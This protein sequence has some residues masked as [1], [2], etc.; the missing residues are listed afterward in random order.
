VYLTAHTAAQIQGYFALA[1][2]GEMEIKGVQGAL[3]VYELSP[4]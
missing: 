4:F 1:D 3:H 2:L